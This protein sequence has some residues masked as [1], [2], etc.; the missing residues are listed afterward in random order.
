MPFAVLHLLVERTIDTLSYPQLAGTSW[1]WSG[2]MKSGA[3]SGCRESRRKWRSIVLALSLIQVTNAFHV[4]PLRVTRVGNSRTDIANPA[5]ESRQAV[6]FA[7]GLYATSTS[8]EADSNTVSASTD[9]ILVTN[10]NNT[11][12]TRLAR[13]KD[14][15]W[16][17]ECREDL[18]A[19]EFALS[20]ESSDSLRK[21]K[22][23][24]DYEKLSLQLS[25]R[26][27]DMGC[28]FATTSNTSEDD[29]P[30]A[31]S[32]DQESG[33]ANMVYS[34]EQ[35]NVL[36]DRIVKTRQMLIEKSRQQQH[37]EDDNNNGMNETVSSAGMEDFGFRLPEIRVELPKED[38]LDPMS[39]GPKLY[40]R[41]DGTVDWD[42]ALQDRE[43]LR[44]F[45]TAVWARINGLDPESIGENGQDEGV[46][47]GHSLDNHSPNKVV[48][49]KIEETAEIKA[50]K[51]KLDELNR[52]LSNME[53]Q[54]VNLLNSAISAGQAVANVNLASLAPPQRYKIRK[55][56]EAIVKQK[57]MVQCYT[58]VYELERIYS[59][60]LGEL[61]NPALTGYIPLPDRLN[62]AEF[63]LMES[64]VETFQRQI[65]L[66]LTVDAD[67]LAVVMEQLID[68]K[69]RLGIDYYVTGLSFDGEAIR[70]FIADLWDQT[71]KVFAFYG[72]GCRLF[73]NDCL[74]CL[75]LMNRAAQGYTLKPREVR[76][77]R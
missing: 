25:K 6:V 28:T 76:T 42:G 46:G 71:K 58:L 73:W 8:L 5:R 69:R 57:E 27:Y 9:R 47:N 66:G 15:M 12:S 36:L 64:Q 23:A 53:R 49:A 62:V 67:V 2:T 14:L 48:T 10:T 35:R 34:M 75:I 52:E 55:S 3:E 50:A 33:A 70:R 32:L 30:F 29:Q 60:L 41:D 26:L 61:G 11:L 21:K 31:C 17:R 59:Y 65:D 4:V 38:L 39:P 51:E 54:H 16:V 40:V 68:F 63:G 37:K 56:A 24:V 19:A 45:G 43:A 1:R 20:V 74:F 72:K 77:L 22:R 44:K 18:T 7:S 13:L